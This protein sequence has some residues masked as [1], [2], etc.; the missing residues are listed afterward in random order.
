MQILKQILEYLV[1]Q[2]YLERYLHQI[3]QYLH[4]ILQYL[5]QILQYLVRLNDPLATR[6]RRDRTHERPD[7]RRAAAQ[8]AGALAQASAAWKTQSAA[9][10]ELAS[11]ATRAPRLG[12]DESDQPEERPLPRARRGGRCAQKR[13]LGLVAM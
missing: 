7:A 13:P 10:G 11:R 2:D 4:Q 9:R 1:E 6:S 8:H 3:L 12:D 5:L